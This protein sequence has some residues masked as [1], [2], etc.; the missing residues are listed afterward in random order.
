GK[1]YGSMCV[2]PKVD[3]NSNTVINW[4]YKELDDGSLLFTIGN[5][6]EGWLDGWEYDI[7]FNAP[8]VSNGEDVCSVEDPDS[9]DVPYTGS[10]DNW[11]PFN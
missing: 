3:C 6:I 1:F 4:I 7:G 9:L 2:A 8:D 5:C 11:Y 10:L